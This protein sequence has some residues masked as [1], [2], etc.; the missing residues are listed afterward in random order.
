MRPMGSPMRAV[1][2]SGTVCTRAA[3]CVAYSAAGVAIAVNAG[4]NGVCEARGMRAMCALSTAAIVVAG[5]VAESLA[6]SVRINARI[7]SSR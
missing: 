6:T 1:R 3:V 2:A 7:L 5:G 4:I